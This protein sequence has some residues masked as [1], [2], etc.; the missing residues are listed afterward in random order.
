MWLRRK[1]G[2]YY[3]SASFILMMAITTYTETLEQPQHKMWLSTGK[4]KA[5]IWNVYI[6]TM[7]SSQFIKP[8]QS[9]CLIL[10]ANL[11]LKVSLRGT[12]NS[13]LMALTLVV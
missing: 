6:V 5:R 4:M 2:A 3:P 10:Y 11:Q 13:T 9:K 1:L 8:H 7:K 12:Y